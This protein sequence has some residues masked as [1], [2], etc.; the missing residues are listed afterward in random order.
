VMLKIID[1]PLL[2]PDAKIASRS[3][4]KF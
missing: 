1:P 3:T 4:H 2:N